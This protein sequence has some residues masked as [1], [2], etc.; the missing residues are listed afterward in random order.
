MVLRWWSVAITRSGLFFCHSL[1][2]SHKSIHLS[3]KW[4]N[5]FVSR[6]KRALESVQYHRASDSSTRLYHRFS[7]EEFSILWGRERERSQIESLESRFTIW[8]SQGTSTY[9]SMMRSKCSDGNRKL[10]APNNAFF[11]AASTS[12][13]TRG[14]TK[15]DNRIETFSKFYSQG[16]FFAG[17]EQM[18]KTFKPFLPCP[19]QSPSTSRN[20]GASKTTNESSLHHLYSKSS[21]FSCMQTIFL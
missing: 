6:L 2:Q 20:R 21:V 4:S 11:S 7:F 12:L 1:S 19:Y 16:K 5:S 3:E 13:L 17:V 14:T 8:D 10:F 15:F 18:L 9:R